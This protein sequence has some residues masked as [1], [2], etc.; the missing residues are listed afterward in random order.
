MFTEERV[1]HDL[2]R[3]GG[4][5]WESLV[6]A[7]ESTLLGMMK[8]KRPAALQVKLDGARHEERGEILLRGQ[9]LSVP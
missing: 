1:K 5:L 8:A 2:V 3:P 9:L 6:L 4:A 7:S